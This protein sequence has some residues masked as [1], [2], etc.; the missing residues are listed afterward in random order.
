VALSCD[1]KELRHFKVDRIDEVDVS[2]FPF[3]M[4]DDFQLDDHFAKSF[5][6]FHGD[7]EISVKIKFLPRVARYVT[8]S[9]WHDSQRLTP[10]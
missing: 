5:G 9:K 7:G 2:A 4:P 6:V 3:Q 8:E 1:A 10:H